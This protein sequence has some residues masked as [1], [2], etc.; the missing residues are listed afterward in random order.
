MGTKTS[1]DGRTVPYTTS[2]WK[3]SF[4][5]NLRYFVNY[6][7]NHMYWRYFM[8]NF[9]GRQNDLAGNG[10]P[11]LGNWISGIPF[12]DNARLGDQSLL[13]DEYGKDNPGTTCSTCCHYCSASSDCCGRP[14]AT[15]VP[16][17][18]EALSNSG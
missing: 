16:L 6:Q 3:P 12:I 7:L 4:G 1:R 11:N 2:A 18:A 15:T 13:P 10:E 17:P 14:C 9:A 5:D 8:W